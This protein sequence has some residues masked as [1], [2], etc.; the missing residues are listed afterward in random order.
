MYFLFGI[1][2]NKSEKSETAVILYN[3]QERSRCSQP[4]HTH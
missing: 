1:S 2:Q 3:I 4:S